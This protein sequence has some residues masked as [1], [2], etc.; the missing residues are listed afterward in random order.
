[1]TCS[2]ASGH[3]RVIF[4]A[5]IDRRK[6][7]VAGIKLSGGRKRN[8]DKVIGAAETGAAPRH[9]HADNREVYGADS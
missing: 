3:V 4:D 8:I 1:V 7:L 9:G 2:E 6:I 5:N